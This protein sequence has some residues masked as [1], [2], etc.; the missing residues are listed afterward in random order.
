MVPDDYLPV[1]RLSLVT[2]WEACWWQQETLTVNEPLWNSKLRWHHAARDVKNLRPMS[3]LQFYCTTKSF[4][5]CTCCNCNKSGVTAWLLV[6]GYDVLADSL[7]LVSCI[8]NRK[9]KPDLRTQKREQNIGKICSLCT[10]REKL[11]QKPCLL[12]WCVAVA[13]CSFVVR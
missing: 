7:V 1:I 6:T 5:N 10:R 13:Y 4:C 12:M 3:H 2:L 11:V 9:H 8:A